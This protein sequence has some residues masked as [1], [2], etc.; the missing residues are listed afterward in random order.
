MEL[1]KNQWFLSAKKNNGT[2][3][4]G[5]KLGANAS[6]RLEE[7][8]T[9]L[10]KNLKSFSF[11][12][13]PESLALIEA[14]IE[15]DYVPKL[16]CLSVGNSSWE[17]GSGRDYSKL[18][19]ELSKKKYPSLE[20][21]YLGIWELFH[22]AHAGYGYLGNITDLMSNMRHLK[23]AYIFGNFELDRVLELNQLEKLY[24]KLDDE[25]T[26]MNGGHITQNTLDL[27]LA[28]HFPQLKELV[29]D[30]DVDWDDEDNWAIYSMPE[31]LL[32]GDVFPKLKSLTVI[33]N[34]SKGQLN[35][36]LDSQLIKRT[37]FKIQHNITDHAN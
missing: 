21:L 22:N 32:D 26:G 20:V 16:E 29:L 6:F 17:L 27:L 7:S 31:T 23:T 34:Y 33:G 25:V 35:K 2:I 36:L 3:P 24:I 15:T 9:S 4:Y 10:P 12:F 5:C 1:P 11:Y 30:L 14:F 18:V 19:I 8:F 13:G 28:S 37:D